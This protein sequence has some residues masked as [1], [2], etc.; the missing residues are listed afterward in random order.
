MN[1]KAPSPPAPQAARFDGVSFDVLVERYAAP[2][3]RFFRRRLRDLSQVENL[4]QETFLRT[5]RYADTYSHG[6]KV[7]ATLYRH[8][9][10]LRGQLVPAWLPALHTAELDVAELPVAS[11]PY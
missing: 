2:L 11:L 7:S 10:N 9:T 6:G 4:V 3:Q 1:Q 5:F 8:P